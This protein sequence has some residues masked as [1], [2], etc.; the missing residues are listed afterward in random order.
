MT[1][2]AA[3]QWIKYPTAGVPRLPNGTSI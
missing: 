3:A 2:A 1:A